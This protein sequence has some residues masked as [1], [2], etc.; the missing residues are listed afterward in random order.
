M[1]DRPA[2]LK[3]NAWTGAE[4]PVGAL[5]AETKWGQRKKDTAQSSK[6]LAPPEVDERDW[7]HPEVGWVIIL[8]DRDDLDDAARANGEDAPEPIRRLIESRPGAVVLRF[9]PELGD[10]HVRR[11]YAH[12]GH[13]DLALIG[14][15]P[16]T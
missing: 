3:L 16:G 6:L 9:R 11:Y 1:Y 14:S 15:M 13:Q 4:S 7:R 8:C 5:P 12:R 2:E 10:G